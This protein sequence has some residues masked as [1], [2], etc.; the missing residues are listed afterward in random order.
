MADGSQ[1][2]ER[3]LTPEDIADRLHVSPIT[4]GKW[5]RSG[6]LK[7]FKAGR[8]W[9]VRENDLQTFLNP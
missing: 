7:G 9:R 5:L 6:K 2:G 4:V 1:T 8:L 3:Y